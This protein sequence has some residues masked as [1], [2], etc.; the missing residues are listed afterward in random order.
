[1]EPQNHVI[2]CLGNSRLSAYL[3]DLPSSYQF[4]TFSRSLENNLSQSEYKFELT[5]ENM[6]KQIDQ[7][8]FQG[9]LFISL[10]PIRNQTKEIWE[11]FFELY[12]NKF[13]QVVLI[14]TTSVYEVSQEH[15][16]DIVESSPRVPDHP[17]VIT[18]DIVLKYFPRAIILRPSGLFDHG[19]HPIKFLARKENAYENLSGTVNLVHREDLARAALFLLENK[20]AGIFNV[21]FPENPN[22][23]SYYHQAAQTFGLELKGNKDSAPAYPS[24]SI[25]TK[26]LLSLGYR[27]QYDINQVN[28]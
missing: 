8:P 27:Y 23:A 26:K 25:N 11:K 21:S 7:L 4:L 12:G 5:L 10:T 3:K 9:T 20:F 15:H 17:M 18:E 24:K 6:E 22:K 14:S 1:M 28:S 13:H 16:C 19:S 2:C